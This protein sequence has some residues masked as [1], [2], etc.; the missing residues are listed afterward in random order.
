[1]NRRTAEQGTA[2]YRS[3]RYRFIP[4][5]KLLLFDIPCSTFDIQILITKDA[6]NDKKIVLSRDIFRKLKQL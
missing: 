3:E 5:K 6:E 4:F 1:L 2:E